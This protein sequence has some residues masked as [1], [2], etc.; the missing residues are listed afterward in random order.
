MQLMSEWEART[1]PQCWGSMGHSCV[2]T[3]HEEDIG[4]V[5]STVR[6]RGL[7]RTSL[8]ILGSYYVKMQTSS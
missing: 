8:T 1:L 3:S 7:Q 6:E 5:K 4:V 2:E